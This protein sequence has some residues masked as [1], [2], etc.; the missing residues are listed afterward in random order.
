MGNRKCD[1]CQDKKDILHCI[2]CVTSGQKVYIESNVLAYIATYVHGSTHVKLVEA[3][4]DH[5]KPDVIVQA[6]KVLRDAVSKYLPNC[7]GLK[8][9]RVNSPRRENYVAETEDIVNAMAD[10]GKITDR[11]DSFPRFVTEDSKVSDLPP[12][13][14]ET[15]NWMTVMELLRVQESELKSLKSLVEVNR[16][17]IVEQK[18][19]IARCETRSTGQQLKGPHWPSLQGPSRSDHRRNSDQSTT[20]TRPVTEVNS[21][22]TARQDAAHNKEKR[23]DENVISGTSNREQVP[24]E[25]NQN[26]QQRNNSVNEQNTE[27]DSHSTNTWQNKMKR[28]NKGIGGRPRRPGPIIG[29]NKEGP[30]RITSGPSDAYIKIW[31]INPS[32]SEEDIKEVIS[33][34]GVEVKDIVVLSKPEWRTKSFKVTI[35]AKDKDKVFK[36]E[37]WNEGVKVGHFFVNRRPRNQQETS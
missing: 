12:C 6:K 31:N 33:T 14:P 25:T 11:D 18:S 9:D 10:L 32:C 37:L 27:N 34:Q 5:F 20:V 23:T 28:T 8:K 35:S 22:A 26:I 2:D 19:A 24:N 29:T 13:A 16:M 21:T 17:E 3:V 30:Q 7:E 15:A 1:K 4:V 36:P